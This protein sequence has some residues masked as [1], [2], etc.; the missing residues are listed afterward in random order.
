M[1]QGP[2]RLLCRSLVGRLLRERRHQPSEIARKSARQCLSGARR[3]Y[4][5]QSSRNLSRHHQPATVI[6]SI[7][8]VLERG[9]IADALVAEIATIGRQTIQ[10]LAKRLLAARPRS[11]CRPEHSARCVWMLHSKRTRSIREL[12]R[13][14]AHRLLGSGEDDDEKSRGQTID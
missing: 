3:W 14:V 12:C 13:S 9:L 7:G 4:R 5:R 1:A 6:I 8:S 11:W 2:T 10:R